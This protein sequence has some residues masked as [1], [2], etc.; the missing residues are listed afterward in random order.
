MATKKTATKKTATRKTTT[1]VADS[2]A[3]TPVAQ[4]VTMEQ[5]LAQMENRIG[6]LE[7]ENVTLRTELASRDEATETMKEG[8]VSIDSVA[9]RT[10]GG[11]QAIIDEVRSRNPKKWDRPA[12]AKRRRQLAKQLETLPD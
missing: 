5:R 2:E 6:F 7:N 3:K 10:K 8:T 9:P 11:L 4:G 1:S 12:N